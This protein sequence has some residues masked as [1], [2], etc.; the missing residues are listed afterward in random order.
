MGDRGDGAH[1]Q[2][3]T[4]W[5]YSVNLVNVFTE[6]VNIYLWEA[7]GEFIVHIFA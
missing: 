1:G 2:W 5:M 4:Y 7:K 3:G 6:Y